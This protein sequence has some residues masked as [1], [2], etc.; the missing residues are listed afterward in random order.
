MNKIKILFLIP[1]LGGGGAEKVL[2]NLVNNLDSSKYDITIKTIFG[3][4]TNEKFLN[5]N[6]KLS[7]FFKFKPF[8]G[9][10]FIQ[11]LFKPSFLY[12][13]LIKEQY[14]I[15]I[16]FLQHAPTR[17]LGASSNSKKFAWIHNETIGIKAYRNLNEFKRTYK[18]F[19]KIAFVSNTAKEKFELKYP[20]F[21]N[22]QVVHNV[23]ETNKLKLLA[24]EHINLQWESKVINLCSI[25]RLAEQ[26]GYRR[27]ILKLSE[28]KKE[29]FENW[30]LYILGDGELKKELQELINTEKLNDKIK[31]LGY[32]SN[33]YKYLK[34]MDLFICS[35]FYEGF[36][37]AVTE[38]IILGIPVLSTDC[39]G[40]DEIID[41][42]GAG[43]IVP[44]NDEK[45]YD[46]LKDLF[47]NPDKLS[48]M[49]EAAIKRSDFFTTDKAIAEFEKFIN[50]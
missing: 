43:I 10:V 34:K 48:S 29:G 45:L 22:Y 20:Y 28:L 26:K 37:T 21:L 13:L 30:C 46:G 36:S 49:K 25:G 8:R 32:Q 19:N 12:K 35:S 1:N 27:L 24:K 18:N 7:T 6:I 3:Q 5:S 17:I 31:L 50:D 33:P 15:E 2:V 39:A 47:Q 11:K 9:W 40:M 16:A 44:N 4:G 38:A 14:D 23:N 41:N 42:S